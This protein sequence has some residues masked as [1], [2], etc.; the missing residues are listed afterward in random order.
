VT[1]GL[2]RDGKRAVRFHDRERLNFLID[3]VYA[4]VM[5]LLVLELRPPEHVRLESLRSLLVTMRPQL[6]AFAI[7]FAIA[8]SGWAF[9]HQAG[10][11]FKKSSFLHLTLN[12]FALMIATTLPFSAAVMSSEPDAAL[13]PQ[14]YAL[15]VGALT[16][17]Y[18][19]DVGLCGPRLFSKGVFQHWLGRFVVFG[20]AGMV[21][22]CLFVAFVI[23]PWRPA[24][25]LAALGLHF[26]GHST[27]LALSARAVDE[28]AARP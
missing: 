27:C 13:G 3:G 21:L 8:A 22:W 10:L 23:A 15:N 9:V 25:A 16:T 20:C 4:I 26:V 24:L 19:V 12:L 2:A 17:I 5:T 28:A 14:L 11:L 7:A 1:G 6:T 18:A